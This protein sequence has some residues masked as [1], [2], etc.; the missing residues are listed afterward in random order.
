V[1]GMCC[2]VAADAAASIVAFPGPMG[3]HRAVDLAAY[4]GAMV[5]SL[6]RE[7]R[8]GA[9]RALQYEAAPVQCA[10]DCAVRV[11]LI[12]MELV[13]PA[14]APPET[15][16]DRKIVVS[17]TLGPR[18]GSLQIADS[19]PSGA[20]DKIGIEC[21]TALAHQLGGTLTSGDAAARPAFGAADP[22][23]SWRLEF[24]LPNAAA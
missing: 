21:S 10:F 6:R 19:R 4:L 11:G 18:S 22:G 13:A 3:E 17:L 9:T 14:G 20:S 16:S 24:A 5:E 2:D 1:I 23:R 7:P 8:T 15:T 12:L